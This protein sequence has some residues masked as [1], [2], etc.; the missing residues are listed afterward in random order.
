MN[1]EMPSD[2][3]PLPPKPV[4]EPLTGSRPATALALLLKRL[5]GYGTKYMDL[6]VM[7][8][9]DHHRDA[10]LVELLELN[11]AP[12]PEVAPRDDKDAAR[13]RW[14]CKQN[15]FLVYIENDAGEQ[16]KVRLRCGAPLDEWLDNRLA[17]ERHQPQKSGV[18]D[19]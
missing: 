15:N 11:E 5:Q 8:F 16:T 2:A 3:E 19:V 9:I 18:T 4:A 17:E 7:D 10:L 13:Y 1:E 6:E 12:R 14:L